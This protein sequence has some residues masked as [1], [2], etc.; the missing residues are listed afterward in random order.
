M[1]IFSS[2]PGYKRWTPSYNNIEED[3]RCA[4]LSVLLILEAH[5]MMPSTWVTYT[6]RRR[7]VEDWTYVNLVFVERAWIVIW[8]EASA[9]VRTWKEITHSSSALQQRRTDGRRHTRETTETGACDYTARSW[10]GRRNERRKICSVFVCQIQRAEQNVHMAILA[11]LFRAFFWEAT[12]TA[13]RNYGLICTGKCVHWEYDCL[14][15]FIIL[16]L[17][18]RSSRF[19]KRFKL[20]SYKTTRDT[21]IILLQLLY[22]ECCTAHRAYLVLLRRKYGVRRLENAMPIPSWYILIV[23]CQFMYA[24]WVA[25]W[26]HPIYNHQRMCREFESRRINNLFFSSVRAGDIIN[27][28]NDINGVIVCY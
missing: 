9:Y 10:K 2:V 27:G 11:I 4:V 6:P 19:M 22:C 28:Y 21:T 13:C 25:Q 3:K 14:S 12:A 26:V 18:L 20:C 15:S 5:E 16:L 1:Y 23:Q 8:N 24:D 17:I 7:K